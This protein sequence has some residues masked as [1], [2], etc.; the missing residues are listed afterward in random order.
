MVSCHGTLPSMPTTGHSQ[1]ELPALLVSGLLPPGEGGVLWASRGQSH[2]QAFDLSL[3]QSF[4][5]E[6][7]AQLV[8]QETSVLVGDGAGNFNWVWG[9]GG[10]EGV[11]RG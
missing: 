9:S 2:G 6:L 7:K 3:A 8:L 10:G 11:G 5:L 4:H 1:T